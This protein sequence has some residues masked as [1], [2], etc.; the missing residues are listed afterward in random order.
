MAYLEPDV[1]SES[2]FFGHIQTYSH[3]FNN[4]NSNNLNFLTFF[5][6]E[7]VEGITTGE[8]KYPDF[9]KN[10]IEESLQSNKQ[11]SKKELR[12]RNGSRKYADEAKLLMMLCY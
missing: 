4:D 11:K 2:C 10:Y 9:F 1:Y 5:V 6:S 3:T 7:A 12:I 8:R